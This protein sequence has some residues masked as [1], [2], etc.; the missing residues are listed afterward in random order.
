[1]N[2]ESK[3]DRKVN[4]RVY[5]ELTRI[6]QQHNGILFPQDV[7]REAKAINNPLHNYFLWDNNKAA[8]AYRLEQA[9]ALIRVCV[10]YVAGTD[11]KTQVWVSLREDRKSEG[12]Y[13]T[14][15][16]VMSE[17]RLRQ[18]LLQEAMEELLRFEQKYKNLKI[19]ANIF[20][21]SRR[22]RHKMKIKVLAAH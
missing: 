6:Q 12:G 13:R 15:V 3:K 7:V 18:Q 8:H 5:A 20:K 9:R 22:I 2:K 16:S 1:M 10:Q 19:L 11:E 14:L 21:E 4:K 17:P